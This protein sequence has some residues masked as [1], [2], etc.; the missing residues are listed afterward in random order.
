MRRTFFF[1]LGAALALV[2][3]PAKAQP[4]APQLVKADDGVSYA[5]GWV[6]DPV[7]VKQV[8]NRMAR[9]GHPVE[10][11][12]AAPKLM[13]ADATAPVF[14]WHSEAKVLGKV[15]PSWNQGQVGSCVGFGHGRG[16]QDALLNEVAAGKARW[17]GAEISPEVIYGGSRVEVG[18]GGINGDGSI[19]AWAA[20][21]HTDYGEVVRG[22]YGSLDL[23]TYNEATCRRLGAQGIPADV[24]AV[25][26]LHP[27]TE[28]A[29]CTTADELW[30]ALGAGKSVPV[31]SMQG[32]TTQR[33]ADGFCR[34]S[35]Q[36]AHCM[37]YRGRFVHPTR[38]KCV[39][40][41]NSWGGYLGS[42]NAKF[43]YVAADGSIKEETLPEGCFCVELSVAA[44]ALRERDTFV[45]A[46]VSGWEATPPPP[47]PPTPPTPPTPAGPITLT[48]GGQML[49][50]DPA[51]KTVGLPAGWTAAG[52]SGPTSVPTLED[53]LK[54]KGL[55]PE[56]IDLILRLVLT[57]LKREAA[58]APKSSFAP[59]VPFRDPAAALPGNPWGQAVA[60]DGCYT[61][62]AGRTVCPAGRPAPAV[63]AQTYRWTPFGG[64]FRR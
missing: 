13:K 15:L 22:V 7:A 25:A 34:R 40:E 48:V 3:A 16:A 35:G 9:K 4:P 44:E 2:A 12:K 10:F 39:V 62:A 20:E 51:A 6:K 61:D 23:R 17:P 38:G 27:I 55:T 64:R 32:F 36:W 19:G 14:F 50:I 24:E 30:S 41:Q 43:K 18:G 45:L 63:P 11:S 54:A 58:P 47:E 8:L 59:T 53:Q 29:L 49:V 26:K 1:L 21:W 57:F 42:A 31:C 5:T 52:G 28:V 46:G 56:Q 60:G 37:V 33:D